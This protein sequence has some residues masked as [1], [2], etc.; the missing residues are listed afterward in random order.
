MSAISICILLTNSELNAQQINPCDAVLKS[1]KIYY[2]SKYVLA[3]NIKNH[4]ETLNSGSGD[5]STS[6]GANILLP[7]PS[8]LI[9][10]G[11]NYDNNSSYEYFETLLNTFEKN[12]NISFSNYQYIEFVPAQNVTAWSGCIKDVYTNIGFVSYA[13][14]INNQV[15]FTIITPAKIG[16]YT[17]PKSLSISQITYTDKNGKLIQKSSYATL[18]SGGVK[19]FLFDYN[20]NF[21]FSIQASVENVSEPLTFYY[22]K[23]IPA[24]IQQYRSSYTVKDT[25]LGSLSN[26]NTRGLTINKFKPGAKVQVSFDICLAENCV[27]DIGTN[28]D[29][30]HIES[31]VQINGVQVTNCIKDWHYY[32]GGPP[33]PSCHCTGSTT[34]TVGSDGVI[35]FQV[36]NYSH[37]HYPGTNMDLNVSITN[38]TM[39][40]IE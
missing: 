15:Q 18:N 40:R 11:L 22:P 37:C 4:I 14:I 36:L 7:T 33:K 9:P 5:N 38:L 26:N 32:H 23:I 31:P 34:V 35:D 12:T 6:F 28:N 1:T 30:Y 24:P 3:Q 25:T 17:L 20:S 10:L 13:K 19:S 8:G 21:D 2:T 29:K 27:L 39:T 16:A